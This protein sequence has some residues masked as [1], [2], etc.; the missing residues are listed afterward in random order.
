MKG[1][2]I[3][4]YISLFLQ[5]VGNQYRSRHEYMDG[6]T[7][8]RNL[9]RDA[10]PQSVLDHIKAETCDGIVVFIYVTFVGSH[11]TGPM[12]RGSS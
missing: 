8:G 10:L 6:K 1:L 7:N 5:K 2:V 3:F 4:S 12:G 9:R 11:Q